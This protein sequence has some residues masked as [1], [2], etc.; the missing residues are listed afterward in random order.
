MK[1]EEKFGKIFWIEE[2]EFYDPFTDQLNI[3]AEK[4]KPREYNPFKN[5]L[6]RPTVGNIINNKKNE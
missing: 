6:N 4:S 1:Y 5:K 2:G 3:I